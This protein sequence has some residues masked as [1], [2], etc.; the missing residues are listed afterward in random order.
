[1]VPSSLE[2]VCFSPEALGKEPVGRSLSEDEGLFPRAP[3]AVPKD[4]VPHW[5]GTGQTMCLGT[6]Q[7]LFPG[8]GAW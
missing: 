7:H 1:M 2:H 8:M 4:T 5:P 6:G 3:S